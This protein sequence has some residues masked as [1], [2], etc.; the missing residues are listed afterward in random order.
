MWSTATCPRGRRTTR[1]PTGRRRTRMSA[2]TGRLYSE[3][4]FA[5][6]HE[7]DAGGRRA[8]AG[9]FAEQVCGGERL[10]YTLALHKGESD[11]PT[12]RRTTPTR[13]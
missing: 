5:L 2:P 13:T 7:L 9:A 1:T 10:P 8:L 3:I 11:A 4:Q 12:T 6:P